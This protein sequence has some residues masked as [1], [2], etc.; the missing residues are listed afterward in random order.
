MGNN[1]AKSAGKADQGKLIVSGGVVGLVWVRMYLT[2]ENLIPF[3]ALPVE[4]E[5]RFTIDHY[6]QSIGA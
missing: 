1:D 2:R 4:F 6:E 3:I 5:D